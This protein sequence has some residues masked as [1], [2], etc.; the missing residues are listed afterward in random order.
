M[1]VPSS[2][3][4]R[5]DPSI[6]VA[7][8][9][10]GVKVYCSA[11]VRLPAGSL[12]CEACVCGITVLV[13]VR[14]QSPSLPGQYLVF[15]LSISSTSHM[16][17]VWSEAIYFGCRPVAVE[18]TKRPAVYRPMAGSIG[19]ARAC[20]RALPRNNMYSAPVPFIYLCLMHLLIYVCI[21]CLSVQCYTVN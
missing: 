3:Y 1:A 14:G 4:G 8:H 11:R 7:G 5:I 15:D 16:P 19:H 17:P 9:W 18:A 6:T 10:S 12:I 2:P 21:C 13:T 20:V